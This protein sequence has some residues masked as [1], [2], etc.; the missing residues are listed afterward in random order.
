MLGRGTG[1]RAGGGGGEAA[2]AAVVLTACAECGANPA[3]VRYGG[4]VFVLFFCV[5]VCAGAPQ[6]AFGV[7]VER[8]PGKVREFSNFRQVCFNVCS[9]YVVLRFVTE[10]AGCGSLRRRG[11]LLSAFLFGMAFSHDAKQAAAVVSLWWYV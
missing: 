8:L 9:K 5:Y 6:E 1:A 3:K 7:G 10:F 2:A 4:L 11:V